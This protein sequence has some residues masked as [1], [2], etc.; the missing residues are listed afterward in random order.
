M[1]FTPNTGRLVIPFIHILNH[2]NIYYTI[3]IFIALITANWFERI[4]VRGHGASESIIRHFCS[5]RFAA[6]RQIDP[7]PGCL[8][9]TADGFYLAHCRT[10]KTNSCMILTLHEEVLMSFT[11][12]WGLFLGRTLKCVTSPQPFLVPQHGVWRSNT[13][14]RCGC[15]YERAD[16]VELDI[17]SMTPLVRRCRSR[18]PVALSPAP[19]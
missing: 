19:G 18:T 7:M 3:Y 10:K 9:Q 15:A 17:A 4:D 8:A 16:R 6:D 11:R 14:A 2:I 13:S 5:P 12:F 1:G